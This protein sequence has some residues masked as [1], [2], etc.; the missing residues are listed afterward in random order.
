MTTSLSMIDGGGG[1]RNERV[2]Q[3]RRVIQDEKKRL[4]ARSATSTRSSAKDHS[5]TVL[6]WSFNEQQQGKT[7][8]VGLCIETGCL[9]TSH[10]SSLRLAWGSTPCRP[11]GSSRVPSVSCSTPASVVLVCPAVGWKCRS[12]TRR[13]C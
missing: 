9:A 11:T 1:M 12:R 5:R 3:R 7:N 4:R 10:S 13:R 8:A 2:V 6:N